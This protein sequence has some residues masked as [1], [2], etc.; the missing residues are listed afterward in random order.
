MFQSGNVKIPLLAVMVLLG[1][2]GDSQERKVKYTLKTDVEN[3]EHIQHHL[4]HKVSEEAIKR[5]DFTQFHL[6]N[7]YDID[8]NG[9]LD[10]CEL[11]KVTAHQHNHNTGGESPIPTDDELEMHVD[12]LLH[13]Y[14]TNDDGYIDYAEYTIVANKQ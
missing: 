10:G 7:L 5:A 13:Q 1:C 3:I 11:I 8:K 12:T 4:K 6:F 2:I 14:D 9:V